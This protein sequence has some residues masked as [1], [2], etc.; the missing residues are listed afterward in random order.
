M[1]YYGPDWA[2]LEAQDPEIAAA[3]TSELNRQRTH[4]QLIASENL[5]SPAV[6]AASALA[7]ARAL[8]SELSSLAELCSR[9]DAPFEQ[10]GRV[11]VLVPGPHHRGQR[12]GRV[13]GMPS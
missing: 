9:P 10:W 11:A 6:L 2:Q 1:T 8:A 13:C 7:Y 3:I 5:T 4:L 12:H